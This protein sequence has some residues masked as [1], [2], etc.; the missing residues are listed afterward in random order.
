M[1]KKLL[2]IILVSFVFASCLDYSLPEKIE[3][4]IEGSIDLPIKTST[5]NWGSMLAKTLKK[6]FPESMEEMGKGIE[7]YNVNY[8]QD[9]QAFCVYIPIE[10]SDS[11]NPG[12][13]MEDIDKLIDMDTAWKI[14][15]AVEVPSFNFPISCPVSFSPGISSGIITYNEGIPLDFST[16]I[17]LGSEDYPISPYFLH[18]QI[19]EGAF[20]INLDLSK[21][22]VTLEGEFTKVYDIT[23]SQTSDTSSPGYPY[24]GL[25]Y[26]NSAS[27]LKPLNLQHINKRNIMINGKVTLKSKTGSFTITKKSEENNELKGELN[28]TMDI[29]KFKQLDINWGETGISGL[30]TPDPV[31][32]AD[33]AEYLNWIEFDKCDDDT[34]KEPTKGIGI[35]MSFTEIIGGLEMNITCPELSLDATKHLKL[36]GD[37]NNIFGNGEALKDAKKLQLAG[38]GAVTNLDFDIELR[39][40]DNDTVLHIPNLDLTKLE[41][42]KKWIR[43]EAKLF[44]NW[45]QAQ[46]KMT[47][48][49]ET[50]GT[51]PDKGKD[52]DPIDLSLL[53][54]YL[55]GFSFKDI[56][57]AAYLSGPDKTIKSIMGDH[58]SLSIDA[59]YTQNDQNIKF[60]VYPPTSG[61]ELQ[62][63]EKGLV[64]GNYLDEKG[65]YK[66]RELPANGKNEFDFMKIIND[67]PKDLVFQ[68]NVHLPETIDVTREM[69]V[70]NNE[71]VSPNITTT[72]MMLMSMELIAGDRGG[73][74]KFPDMFDKD[75]IDLFDRGRDEND[76]SRPEKNSM[77][78]SLDV[79]YIRFAVDFAGTLFNGGTFF[80]EQENKMILFPEGIPVDG[81]KI[82]LNITNEKFNIIKDNFI[83]PD[84]RLNFRKDSKIT[85]PRNMGLTSVKLE[86]KGKNTLI[87]DF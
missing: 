80:I 12:D 22:G 32:L 10:I 67:M 66:K 58:P 76:P 38:S 84:L 20:D 3:L 5:S 43:G 35:N 7:V 25:A 65:S 15:E 18:A 57:A 34:N 11:L 37:G 83:P 27:N 52:E 44:F 81:S 28:I 51:F 64:I 61:T 45:E 33:I 31:P 69:F 30:I 63:D 26:S 87:L 71:S 40:A 48:I 53:N 54:D 41:D 72:I 4:D 23:I 21:G 16:E 79:E 78:T 60:P 39:P 13:H 42:G 77:F 74:I 9:V 59:L 1:Q 29:R 47:E 86:V 70:D 56:T 2:F 68:Y 6:A 17:N 55:E 75:Q 49:L 46:V 82:A 62:L 50:A 24:K 19:E 8:G 14:E 73:K 85:I 36:K